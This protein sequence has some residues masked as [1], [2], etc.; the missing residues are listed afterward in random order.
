MILSYM[1]QGTGKPAPFCR[2]SIKTAVA[3]IT[4]AVSATYKSD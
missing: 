3:F 1:S 2:L 4:A